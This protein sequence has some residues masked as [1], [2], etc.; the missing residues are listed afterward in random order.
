MN[1]AP[2]S[3]SAEMFPKVCRLRERTHDPVAGDTFAQ[4]TLQN[5]SHSPVG[6]PFRELG[7][8]NTVAWPRISSEDSERIAVVAALDPRQFPFEPQPFGRIQFHGGREFLIGARGSIRIRFR[9]RRPPGRI[10]GLLFHRATVDS[11]RLRQTAR[12]AAFA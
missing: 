4:V 11:K 1:H 5:L 10:G 12:T 2:E 8:R 9:R 3:V 6:A 7:E